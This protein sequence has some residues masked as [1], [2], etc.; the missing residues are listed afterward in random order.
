MSGE[1]YTSERYESRPDWLGVGR[2]NGLGASDSAPLLGF[3]RF[4]SI[5]SVATDKT[6]TAIDNEPDE[7]MEWGHRHEPAIAQKFA[8][9]TGH[10]LTDPGEF[11]IFR[12]KERPHLF[13]TPDRIVNGNAELS[14]KTAY[15]QSGKEWM[16]KIPLQYQIQMQ[17][18][19][20]VTGFDVGFFAVLIDGYK[21]RWHSMRRNQK[22]IDRMLPKLDAFWESIQR[23]EMPAVDGSMATSQALARMYPKPGDGII[24]APDEYATIG[25][26]YD[27]ILEQANQL[28]KR[29]LEIQNC[30]K[31][32]IGENKTAVLTDRSGFSWNG[33]GKGS[34]TFRRVKKVGDLDE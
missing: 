4:K 31:E 8:E 25:E 17:H 6:T 9:V 2:K 1:H 13:C 12:S 5:Y 19:L 18:T 11:T 24:E 20:Y 16:Q 29:K 33:N 15:F 22:W 21:F 34:R 32:I 10:E 14:I 28:E 30:M 3:S 27:A 26:E 23:G 7:M